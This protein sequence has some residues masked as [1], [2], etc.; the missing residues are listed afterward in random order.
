MIHLHCPS[1]THCRA[2]L[3]P[4]RTLRAC[5][6]IGGM[7]PMRFSK[8]VASRW[9]Q[10]LLGAAVMALAVGGLPHP[11]YAQADV[12]Q[13]LRVFLDCKFSCDR[14]FLID[15][16]RYAIWTQDRLDA[17]VHVLITQLT[18]GAGGRAYTLNFIAQRR[19]EADVDTVVVN[20]PPN[21]SADM[22]R[23]ALASVI[24]L[25]LAQ[26]AAQFVGADR[27][28]VAYQAVDEATAARSAP[29][30]DRWNLWVYRASV[31][32]NGSAES[33]SANYQLN[34][35]FNASRVT[36]MWKLSVNAGNEYRAQRFTLSDGRERQFVLR[37]AGADA[38][39]V[40]SISDHWSVGTR[41]NI[42]LS[43]FNNQ[44]AFVQ[45][46][47]SAEYNL[48]PWREATSR[49][50]IALVSIGSRYYDYRET[51]LYGRLTEHRAAAQAVIAGEAR[52][53]WGT[54]DGSLRYRQYLHDV[55]RHNLS[56]FMQTDFRVTRGLSINLRA[57]AAKVQ[58]QLYLPRG[59][60]SDDEVLT[61]QRALATAY[62]LSG[63]VGLSY[64]FGSIYNTIV[65]PRLNDLQ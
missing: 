25:A 33:R 53:P 31:R 38:R 34:A 54:L 46:D 16:H 61:R 6:S 18:T 13:R 19:L 24:N 52:M 2:L 45:T 9:L 43:E 55:S 56:F 26:R 35:D 41:G 29:I 4:C 3:L 63:S 39:I 62:R 58:D 60:A 22:Q 1:G 28:R 65:N 30:T 7:I 17:D 37:R 44:D 49:Q 36:E 15:E 10:C 42:G 32:G 59:E 21:S 11:L 47:I 5:D 48:F 14:A 50:L 51:T 23:R 27:F 40:R 57:E 20:V 12:D 8:R 64:T